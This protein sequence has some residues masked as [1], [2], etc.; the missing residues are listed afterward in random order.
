MIVS[1]PH[2]RE[3]NEKTFSFCRQRV[4][5]LTTG[6]ATQTPKNWQPSGGSRAD[7]SIRLSC[8]YDVAREFPSGTNEELLAMADTRCKA[9]GYQ[10][11]ESYGFIDKKCNR[12]GKF[13]GNPVC[14]EETLTREYQ[15]IGRGD[16]QVSSEKNEQ[17]KN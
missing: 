16:S 5:F 14:I 1:P 17:E 2:R 11:A 7:A 13:L 9:W 6:C 15:C 3:E 8:L 4:L 12:W 10:T